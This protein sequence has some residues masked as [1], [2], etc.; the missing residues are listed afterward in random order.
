MIRTWDRGAKKFESLKDF[1]VRDILKKELGSNGPNSYQ[2]DRHGYLPEVKR[3]ISVQLPNCAIDDSARSAPTRDLEP[4][5]R[6]T[7]DDLTQ[8][9]FY[10]ENQC[11]LAFIMG[12]IRAR[13]IEFRVAADWN[14][15]SLAFIMKLIGYKGHRCMT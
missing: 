10:D 11:R 9:I 2:V 13:P 5:Q 14:E 4:D 7:Y 6:S 8:V 15:F 12:P 3:E 1:E